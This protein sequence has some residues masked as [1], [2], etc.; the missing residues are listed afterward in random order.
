MVKSNVVEN[1]KIVIG[2]PIIRRAIR[3]DYADSRE[4]ILTIPVSFCVF[5]K[6]I[7]VTFVKPNVVKG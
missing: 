6:P 3:N 1:G 4:I 7:T 5:L 2:W